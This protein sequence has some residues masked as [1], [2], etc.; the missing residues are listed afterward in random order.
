V[1]LAPLIA[2]A[3]VVGLAAPALA[4]GVAGDPQPE[5]AP[6][7]ITSA[8]GSSSSGAALSNGTVVLAEV[9]KD[10]ASIAVC[11]LPPGARKC[12]TTVTLKPYKK[13]SFGT[14]H[15]FASGSK[16]VWVAVEDCCYIPDPV[17]GGAVV[18][19]STN[20]GKTFSGEMKAGS[21]AGTDAGT[22]VGNQLLVAPNLNHSGTQVQA[23]AE[24]PRSIQ[25]SIATPDHAAN[26]SIGLATYNKGALVGSDN[27]HNTKVWYAPSGSDFNSTSAWSLVT[28]VKGE[29]LSAMS[30]SA[31]LTDVHG[32]LTHGEKLRFFNGKS[33]GPGHAVPEPKNPDDGYFTMQQVGSTVH[34]FFLAR[35]DSY[36]VYSETT[37]DGV[38][39]TKLAIY[40]SATQSAQ[41]VPVLGKTG[42][43]VLYEADGQPLVAQPILNPQ[44]VSVALAK[45][46]V[47]VGT[48]TTL[49]GSVSPKVTGTTI[50]LEHKSGG[51]WYPV[52]T[53]MEKASGAFSFKIP[54]T[55]ETYRAVAH[56]IPGFNQYGYSKALTLTAVPKA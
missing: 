8:A 22:L 17:D 34:V 6:F 41:L 4:S 26:Q 52:S 53:T 49:S 56:Q 33:Y 38:H 43:G 31:L 47:T 19:S 27:G 51:L 25:T 35:R 44:R 28:T 50:T 46:T 7:N 21:I 24:K 16:D 13:D 36:K 11:T 55:T 14:P 30:G 10:G 42:A 39:W 23:L 9:L 2:S 32:S 12:H 5:L 29:T 15:V 1:V 18:F 48:S 3:L 40:A 37:K 45:S 20:G 54:G